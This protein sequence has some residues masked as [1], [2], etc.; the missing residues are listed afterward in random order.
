VSAE[1]AGFL[2]SR[3]ASLTPADV[4]AP[5]VEADVQYVVLRVAES[6]DQTLVTLAPPD[7][8][9]VALEDLAAAWR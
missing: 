3:R 6:L 5:I 4:V 8:E 2:R 9:P 7:R 1:L